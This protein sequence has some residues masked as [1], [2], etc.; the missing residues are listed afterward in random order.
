MVIPCPPQPPAGGRGFI[1]NDSHVS[2]QAIAAL[3]HTAKL[4]PHAE[5]FEKSVR[6]ALGVEHADLVIPGA[7]LAFRAAGQI[8][9]GWGAAVE[10]HRLALLRCGR[11]LLAH[12]AFDHLLD[13]VI[14]PQKNFFG[15]AVEAQRLLE[16]NVTFIQACAAAQACEHGAAVA[17]LDQVL[18]RAAAPAVGQVGHVEDHG[19]PPAPD[20]FGDPMA[21]VRHEDP[22]RI[23]RRHGF[24]R[25]L[26]W[27]R[28]TLHGPIQALSEAIGQRAVPVSA[29]EQQEGAMLRSRS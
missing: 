19:G 20:R 12:D 24:L 8:A 21:P 13:Q 26:G 14:G 16:I 6:V 2:M 3:A 5:G 15:A 18:Q 4:Q 25:E 22:L 10:Q 17:A 27:S 11:G 28:D 29:G 9:L 1:R 23:D 7:Q